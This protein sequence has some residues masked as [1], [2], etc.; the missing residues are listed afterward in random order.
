MISE[1][2]IQAI[3][4]AEGTQYEVAAKFGVA[5][6]YVSRVRNGRYRAR[7]KLGFQGA[8]AYKPTGDCVRCGSTENLVWDH[9]DPATKFA[10]VGTMV[11]R[12]YSH[13]QIMAEIAKCQVLCSGCNT[14]KYH[15][16]DKLR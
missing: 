13:E 5:Q 16:E 9:I 8:N 15:H 11:A 6:S 3:H 12:R 10:D 14:R 7:P 2:T 4:E 1:A